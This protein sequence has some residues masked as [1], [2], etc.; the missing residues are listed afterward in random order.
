MSSVLTEVQFN[1]SSKGKALAVPARP[2]YKKGTSQSFATALHEAEDLLEAGILDGP[3]CPGSLASALN[4]DEASE[5]EPNMLNDSVD[6][7]A[8]ARA[9]ASAT[10]TVECKRNSPSEAAAERQAERD[11]SSE[12][13]QTECAAEVLPRTLCEESERT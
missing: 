7:S 10:K 12:A 3:G 9:K 13:Q 11:P 1:I 2:E 8:G 5:S 6:I 4:S